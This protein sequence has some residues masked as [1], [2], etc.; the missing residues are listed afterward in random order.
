MVDVSAVI[1]V[2]AHNSSVAFV[3][4]VNNGSFLSEIKNMAEQNALV[5]ATSCSAVSVAM[6]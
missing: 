1:P 3:L 6:C 4:P 2:H 5:P